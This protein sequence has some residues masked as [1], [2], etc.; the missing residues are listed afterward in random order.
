MLEGF[1]NILLIGGLPLLFLLVLIEG[2]PFIGSFVPGQVL[3]ILV[4]FMI[5]TTN[6]FNLYITI[7]VVF[8][9]ALF[10][11]IIG[12]YIGKKYGYNG[13]KIFKLDKKSMIYKSSENFFKKFGV[14]SIILGR[15]FNLTRA[16]MPFFAGIFKMDTKKFIFLAIISNLIWSLLSILLG[17][18]FGIIVIDKLNLFFY[19]LVFLLIYSI[20]I[21][22]IYRSFIEFNKKNDILHRYYGLRNI[23]GM[24]VLLISLIL[25]LFY[26]KWGYK[27]LFNE[28]FVILFMPSLYYVGGVLLSKFFLFFLIWLLLMF[29]IYKKDFQMIILL[30]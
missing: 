1:L 14:F 2:N 20:I 12:Y 30:I 21:R 23:F 26:G 16:F 4:G 5:A 8:F 28:Q 10:G 6:S 13:L 17:F 7:C 19:F 29:L 15:E 9:G 24:F 18:Y 27:T 22:I 3:T 25:F 11:D